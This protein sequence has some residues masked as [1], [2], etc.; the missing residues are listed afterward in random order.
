MALVAPPTKVAR[1]SRQSAIFGRNTTVQGQEL[2]RVTQPVDEPLA[3]RTFPADIAHTIPAGPTRFCPTYTFN[4][5]GNC[6]GAVGLEQGLGETTVQLHHQQEDAAAGSP[7]P[8]IHCH[9]TSHHSW[10]NDTIINPISSRAV[11]F[12]WYPT[13]WISQCIH[14]KGYIPAGGLM[15]VT[16]EVDLGKFS[17]VMPLKYECPARW[18]L[19]TWAVVYGTGT[20]ATRPI[21]RTVS[22]CRH[23]TA[24]W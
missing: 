4:L 3:G 18:S 12:K 9:E 6:S 23:A 7:V 5:S 15:N 24:L 22:V 19:L 10:R 20:F 16:V 11:S 14:R 21:C 1:P 8:I 13:R 2:R 17:G